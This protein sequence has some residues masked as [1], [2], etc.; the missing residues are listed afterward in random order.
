MR[1]RIPYTVLDDGFGGTYATVFCRVQLGPPQEKAPRTGVL[2]AVLDSGAGR[3]VFDAVHAKELGVDLYSGRQ[4]MTTGIGGELVVWV[5][6]VKL[7]FGGMVFT[8]EAAFQE[9]LPVAGILGMEGFFEHFIITFDPLAQ[10]CQL[11]RIY[12]A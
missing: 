10:E 3:C 4:E 1:V 8:V 2:R 7:F 5:H 11:D 9:D 6:T 12:R